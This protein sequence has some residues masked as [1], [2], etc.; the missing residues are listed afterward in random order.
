M[1][2]GVW[3]RMERLPAGRMTW[4]RFLLEMVEITWVNSWLFREGVGPS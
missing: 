3:E 4:A 2:E 1:T